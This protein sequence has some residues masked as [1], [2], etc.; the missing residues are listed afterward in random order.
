MVH[1]EPTSCVLKINLEP[2]L[3]DSNLCTASFQKEKEKSELR[4]GDGGFLPVVWQEGR[5]R[6]ERWR[7]LVVLQASPAGHI[8][9]LMCRDTHHDLAKNPHIGLPLPLVG[10]CHLLLAVV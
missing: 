7:F 3:R 4:G 5:G 1:A 10:F 8:F 6:D 2:G 9:L